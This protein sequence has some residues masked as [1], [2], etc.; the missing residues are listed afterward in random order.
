MV[1]YYEPVKNDSLKVGIG[2]NDFLPF[3]QKGYTLMLPENKEIKGVLI[4]LEDSKY[5][6]KNF[7]SKQMYSQASENK[8]AVLSISTEI[9]L[10]F[11]FSNSSMNSTHN[12]VGFPKNRTVHYS[13]LL[14][15]NSNCHDEK[16]Q[17]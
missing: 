4:F 12:F 11:Y 6:K 3:I 7:S 1:E 10:D 5:D 2:E 16:Q 17:V 13:N 8:F 15:L 9:P 14:T